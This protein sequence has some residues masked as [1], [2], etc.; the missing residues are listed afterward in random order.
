MPGE[1]RGRISISVEEA[2]EQVRTAVLERLQHG[3]TSL[4]RRQ[5]LRL[6]AKP[7]AAMEG[8]NFVVQLNNRERKLLGDDFAVE[9]AHLSGKEG[10]TLTWGNPLPEAESGPVIADPSG[11][12]RWD[13]RLPSRLQRMWPALRRALAQQTGLAHH[14]AVGEDEA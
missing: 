12:Q 8:E 4:S 3:K 2:L 9:L 1:I 13:T 10:V 11:K 14:I 5:L 7:L 6:I